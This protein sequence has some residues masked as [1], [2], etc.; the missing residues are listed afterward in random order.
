MFYCGTHKF[1]FIY[2]TFPPLLMRVCGISFMPYTFCTKRAPH[3]LLCHR[4]GSIRQLLV[5]DYAYK[6]KPIYKKP[7]A[8][9]V[10]T[11]LGQ[12]IPPTDYI[13]VQMLPHISGIHPLLSLSRLQGVEHEHA[14]GHGTYPT[15]HGGD[16]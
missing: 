5:R 6:A 12:P 10:D 3:P 15:R 1:S 2:L 14:D 9:L 16:G 8:E 4:S 7:L 13:R 11:L